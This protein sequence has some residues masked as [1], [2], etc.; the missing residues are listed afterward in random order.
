MHMS[1]ALLS[2]EIGVSFCAAT[3]GVI[4]FSSY[5]LKINT[6]DK[7]VPLMGVLGAF[8]FAMQMINFTIP[9]TGSSGHFVGGLLLSILL[10]P[11]A[12]VITIASVLL[13]Q[14]LFF[15]DGGIL[16]LGANIWNMGVYSCFIAYPIYKL[17]AHSSNSS[18][19]LF[20]AAVT[21]SVIGLQAGAISVVLQTCLSGRTELPF[22]AFTLFMLPIHL[23]IG[24]VEG[25]VTA[26][27]I[28]FVKRERPEL[29]TFSH[30]SASSYSFKKIA[31]TFLMTAFIIGG[32]VS[33][34]ASKDPDGLQWSIS[35]ITGKTELPTVINSK[36][37]TFTKELQEKKTAILPDYNIET[38]KNDTSKPNQENSGKW[39]STGK[40]LSGIVGS[41]MVL[42][43]CVALSFGISAVRKRH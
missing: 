6:E 32:V 20:F 12:G 10:G 31:I 30:H 43:L 1:D 37:H 16:A 17:I 2:P 33:W 15:A 36:L 14:A 9:F 3:A 19:R 34:F 5:K 22:G 40:S 13:V 21:A 8:V 4:A 24:I 42:A 7:L 11:Y 25:A 29:L 39:F 35:K 38:Q 18:K 28:S 23:G 41:L 27:I 26:G